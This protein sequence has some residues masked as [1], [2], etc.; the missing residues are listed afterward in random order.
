MPGPG[1]VADVGDLGVPGEQPVHQRAVGVT[2]ARV[3]DEA[4]GLGDHDHVVVLVAHHDVDRRVGLRA[5]PATSGSPSSSITLAGL[6]PAALGAPLAVDEHRARVDERPA[7][8]ARVQP[9]SS[10]TARST[11]SPASASGTTSSLTIDGASLGRRVPA[12][13]S[14]DVGSRT[15][16][17][18]R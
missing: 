14:R 13:R 2:G 16:H 1:R 7:P 3:H 4:G 9:V 8:R 5:G 18:A 11:R 17:D 15:A 12:R 10:A 6:E